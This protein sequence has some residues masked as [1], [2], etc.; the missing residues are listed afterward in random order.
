[1]LELER[2]SWVMD[3]LWEVRKGRE[4]RITTRFL[5][6]LTEREEISFPKMVKSF[7]WTSNSF[8][9]AQNL[10]VPI[11]LTSFY[12]QA[13]NK[14]HLVFVYKLIPSS[15][16]IIYLLPI[17]NMQWNLQVC[18]ALKRP[19]RFFFNCDFNNFWTALAAVVFCSSF[20]LRRTNSKMVRSERVQCTVKIKILG[21]SLPH[22]SFLGNCIHLMSFTTDSSVLSWCP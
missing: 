14:R 13:Q 6:S 10:L 12:T 7:L 4:W 11:L 15:I 18:Y 8:S 9:S 22:V 16:I 3:H 5:Q 20:R 21:S 19:N 1:M 2:R 17:I